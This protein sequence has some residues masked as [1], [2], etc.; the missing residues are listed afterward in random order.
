LR[1]KIFDAQSGELKLSRD[2]NTR[3]FGASVQVTAGGILVNTGEIVKLYSTDFE[4]VQNLAQKTGAIEELITSIS[5]TGK[6]IMLNHFEPGLNRS[7]LEVIDVNTL[8]SRGTWVQAPRLYGDYSISDKGIATVLSSGIAVADFGSTRWTTIGKWAGMCGGNRPVLFN[9][10]ALVYGCN[11]LIWQLTDGRILMT[12]DL[13]GDERA[14]AEKA[15]ARREQVVAVSL[16][17]VELSKHFLAETTSRVTKTRIVVYDLGRE[18][19]ALSAD[20]S[21]VPKNGY[22]FDVSPDG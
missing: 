13:D 5:P 15:V 12:A 2:V 16:D 6:T 17:T 18:V 8:I 22:G 11:R 4:R 9:D 19:P 14:S 1:L 7:K 3:P 20:V 10:E 21:P